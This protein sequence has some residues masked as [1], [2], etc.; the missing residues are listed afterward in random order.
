MSECISV[1]L[2]CVVADE[3]E[4]EEFEIT[5]YSVPPELPDVMKAQDGPTVPAGLT[6]D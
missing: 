2:Y 4:F 5:P 3:N 1:H 6:A